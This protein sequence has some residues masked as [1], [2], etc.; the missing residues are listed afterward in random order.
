MTRAKRIRH[1]NIGK[2]RIL[3]LCAKRLIVKFAHSTGAAV[4]G[5]VIKCCLV[6]QEC[7]S[8]LAR[9]TPHRWA[10]EAYITADGTSLVA[11]AACSF[12]TEGTKEGKEQNS[13]RAW[14]VNSM[15]HVYGGGG[16]LFLIL[17]QS[18]QLTKLQSPMGSN[19]CYCVQKLTKIKS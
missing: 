17:F 12:V 15:L 10:V 7:V 3:C 18:L 19:I 11:E 13:K 6:P 2:G 8:L 16:T 5:F 1:I 4:I 14:S 9:R